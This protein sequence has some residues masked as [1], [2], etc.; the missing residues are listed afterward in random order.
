MYRGGVDDQTT[1]MD[2]GG[3]KLLSSK[4]RIQKNSSMD[5]AIYQEVLRKFR[6][7]SIE[8]LSVKRYRAAIKLLSS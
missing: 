4:Q 1:S 7:T 3:V 8:E 2:R 6:K 5:Q